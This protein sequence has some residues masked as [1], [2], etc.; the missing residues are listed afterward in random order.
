MHRFLKGQ[1]RFDR[2]LLLDTASKRLSLLSDY[3]MVSHFFWADNDTILGYM[4]GPEN[5]DAYWLINLKTLEFNRLPNHALSELGDGHPHVFG[6]WFVTDTYPDKSRMQQLM[7]CNWRTGE[8]KK[9]GEFFH[10]FEFEGESR[11]DLHPRFSMDGKKV[12]FDSVFTGKRQLYSMDVN[13]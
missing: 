10:G 11:C 12:F 9:L 8:V 13:I 3:G 7:L 2:L 6:D 5:V 1:R 4:R